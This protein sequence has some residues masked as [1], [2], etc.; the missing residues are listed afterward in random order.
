[1]PTIIHPD[2]LEFAP[3][4]SS[5]DQ[6]NMHTAVPRLSELVKS[7]YLIFDIRS[8]DPGKYSFPYHFHHYAEEV[9]I[10]FSGSAMLR[11][12][13]G[14]QEL[15]QG[16]I[17]FF[18]TGESSAH[19]LFNHTDKPCVYLDIR[20]TI[21]HDVTEYPDSGKINVFPNRGVFEKHSRVDYYKGEEYVEKI[22]DDLKKG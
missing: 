1:M 20:T 17:V 9:F 5:L 2:Q 7:K 4:K 21:G 10:L 16:E 18:E 6:F 13:E 19:Q 22:W 11:T 12:P 3:G 14:L 15:Q 8:L